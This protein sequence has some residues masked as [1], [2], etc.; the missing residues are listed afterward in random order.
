MRP[1]TPAQIKL[2]ETFADQAV[3]AIENVRLFQELQE[4]TQELARSVGELKAFGEVGQAV[5]STLDLE[6]VLTRIVSHAVQLSGTD[7]G[8][9]YEY[10]EEP[11]EFHFAEATRWK[12]NWLRRY[13]QAPYISVAALL[14]MRH[15]LGLPSKC[16]TSSKSGNSARVECGRS[17]DGS[18]IVHSW[19][20][21]FFADEQIMGGL[22]IFRR[23]PGSFPPEVI[24]LLQTFATQSAL[25][26]QNARL[27]REIEDKEPPDR[28]RQPAQI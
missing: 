1:F 8:V 2:L 6:T 27:F 5:S 17:R 21:H 28:S 10:D 7:C 4:R 13:A 22:T 11:E 25:A 9:I 20:F 3:I 26:I 23:I 15:Y 14:G 18:A 16:R 19:L 12:R 24:N